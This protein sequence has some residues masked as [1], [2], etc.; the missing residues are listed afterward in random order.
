MQPT[1]YQSAYFGCRGPAN[2]RLADFF[3]LNLDGEDEIL[4]CTKD[5]EDEAE[6]EYEGNAE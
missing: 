1:Q 2:S 3:D 5:D 4:D 6:M